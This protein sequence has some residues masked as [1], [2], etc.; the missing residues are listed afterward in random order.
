MTV[1]LQSL[2][3]SL[4]LSGNEPVKG[5]MVLGW[6]S[7]YPPLVRIDFYHPDEP[8]DPS[9]WEVSRDVLME[10]MLGEHNRD[11]GGEEFSIQRGEASGVIKLAT[12]H[13]ASV[14]FPLEPMIKF[15]MDSVREVPRGEVESEILQEYLDQWLEDTL[16]ATDE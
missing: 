6:I 8:E 3:C 15:L 7:D 14:L 11:Y 5:Q 10:C 1:L 4:V 9:R 16:E 13:K 2:P 12:T